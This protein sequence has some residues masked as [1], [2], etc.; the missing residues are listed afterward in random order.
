MRCTVVATEDVLSTSPN[1]CTYGTTIV[2]EVSAQLKIDGQTVE[3]IHK[4][5][6]ETNFTDSIL[7]EVTAVDGVEKNTYTLKFLVPLSQN[8]DLSMIFLDGDSLKNFDPTYY[9]YQV[10]LPVGV[11][12]MPEVAV[13]KGEA[14]QTIKDIVIDQDKLQATIKVLAED[15]TV[16]ENTYVVVFHLTQSEEDKLDM[17]YEDGQ[18]LS[19]FD[20]NTM[21]YTL[22]LPVGTSNFPDLG[23]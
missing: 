9:F 1:N 2:P 20:E 6:P 23:W 14:G 19:G 5:N 17:I 4:V 13:Q 15:K 18:P 12:T 8:A 10:E 22:S 21:Y 3:I 16:R 11:H 7:L